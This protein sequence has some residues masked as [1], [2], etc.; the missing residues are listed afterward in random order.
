M[1]DLSIHREAPLVHLINTDLT[2]L[3]QT[4]LEDHLTKLREMRASP[5]TARAKTER[6]PKA[7]APKINLNSML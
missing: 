5:A 4:E 6:K 7:S 2:K 3:S 1:T